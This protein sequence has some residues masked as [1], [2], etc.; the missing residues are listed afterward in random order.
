MEKLAKKIA[1]NIAHQLGY[2]EEK[3]AVVAYGLFAIFQIFAN[4]LLVLFL[5]ILIA[6]PAEAMIV[7][8]SVG[9]LRKYSGGVHAS[10]AALCTVIEAV[11]CTATALISKRLILSAYNPEVMLAVIVI[12]YPISFITV[13][14][15]APVDSPQKP[16][17]TEKKRTRMKKGS[18][19]VL[20]FYFTL[21]VILFFSG[22]RYR[23]F[24]SYG[25]SLL[26]GVSWQVFTLTP[27]CANLLHRVD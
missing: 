14:K 16:I 22:Y 15:Y 13:K 2:D 21:S 12:L 25:I 7:C 4:I 1:G 17:R 3:E 11:Y 24:N 26:F 8:L 23:L 19:L 5:G 27:L 10:S 20:S 18:L 6:A 9:I